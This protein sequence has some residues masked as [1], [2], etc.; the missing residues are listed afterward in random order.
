MSDISISKPPFSKTDPSH[1]TARIPVADLDQ[2]N[3][4][5]FARFTFNCSLGFLLSSR[6]LV[7]LPA[8]SSIADLL[9]W[10]DCSG[11]DAFNISLSIHG[12]V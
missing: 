1:P 6:H 9:Y 8:V 12:A 3:I 10:M 7:I 11:S 5:L 4:K 2:N